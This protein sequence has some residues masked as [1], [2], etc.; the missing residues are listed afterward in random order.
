MLGSV[1]EVMI[2]FFVVIWFVFVRPV[3]FVELFI[4]ADTDDYTWGNEHRESFD[5]PRFMAGNCGAELLDTRQDT[6]RY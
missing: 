3:E 5:H 4:P 2:S 6:S 1:V